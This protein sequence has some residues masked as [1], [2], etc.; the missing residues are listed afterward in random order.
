MSGRFPIAALLSCLIAVLHLQGDLVAEAGPGTRRMA[1]RLAQLA[2]NAD[3]FPD[4]PM[5][6]RAVAQLRRRLQ[7]AEDPRRQMSLRLQVALKLLRS[8]QSQAAIRELT[9]LQ[10]WVGRQ[11]WQLSGETVAVIRDLLA[12]SHLRLGEQENCIAAH[13][14]HACFLPVRESGRHRLQRGSRGPSP[15]CTSSFRTIPATW[16]IAGCS[17]WPT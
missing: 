9:D 1:A 17:T 7:A 12:V 2:R 8:G 10:A 11:P 16:G 3:F 14:E 6:T 15:S 5:N 4:H 13:G